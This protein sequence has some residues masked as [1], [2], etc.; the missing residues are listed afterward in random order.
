MA[1]G[2]IDHMAV[3]VD[4]LEKAEEYFIKK[5]G[6]KL[7]RRV[8]EGKG[9]ELTSPAGDFVLDIAQGNE[10]EWRAEAREHMGGPGRLC[11]GGPAHFSH[12][13]FK[14][15]DVNKEREELKSKGVSV[16]PH[17]SGFNPVSRRKLTTIPDADGRFWIQLSETVCEPE[18]VD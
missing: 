10:E 16:G 3:G 14:V 2:K 18:K 6:F 4:D 15:D 1:L 5:L 8:Y 12:I 11:L 9:L 7:L 17:V 13:A